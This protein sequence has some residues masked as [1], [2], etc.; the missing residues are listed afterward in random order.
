[1]ESIASID[2]ALTLS[3]NSLHSPLTDSVW[4]F[5]SNREV[6]IPLYVVVAVML[7]VRLGWKKATCALIGLALT[8]V[9]CDQCANLL[10]FGVARLRPCHDAWM[11]ERGLR[12]LE[13]PGGLYGFFSAHAANAFGFAVCSSVIFNSRSTRSSAIYGRVISVW[14]LLVSASRIFVGKHFF[15]DVLVGMA[16][17]IA[18]GWL[19]GRLSCAIGRCTESGRL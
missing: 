1:M 15:G 10:K 11:L 4:M 19:F 17:G 7:Y 3:I 8:I 18:F 9:A 5:F 6:W 12:V 14:A 16:I 13:D 2:R